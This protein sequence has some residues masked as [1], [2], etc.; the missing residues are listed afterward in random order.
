MNSSVEQETQNGEKNP[1]S[2]DNLGPLGVPTYKGTGERP[3]KLSLGK[4]FLSFLYDMSCVLKWIKYGCIF[5]TQKGIMK[6][7]QESF[8]DSGIFLT[9]E[10][11]LFTTEHDV[12]WGL[13]LPDRGGR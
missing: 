7:H 10:E 13:V 1:G 3:F 4:L 6:I 8:P 12:S 11:K 2:R 9:L 5:K